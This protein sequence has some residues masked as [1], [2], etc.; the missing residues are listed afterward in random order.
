[1]ANLAPSPNSLM[2]G[3][4]WLRVSADAV[5]IGAQDEAGGVSWRE[6]AGLH[7]LPGDIQHRVERPDQPPLGHG[8]DNDAVFLCSL[9]YLQAAVLGHGPALVYVRQLVEAWVTPQE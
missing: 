4:S 5:Q 6:P 9:Q 1:M 7:H 3:S 2:I 8:G